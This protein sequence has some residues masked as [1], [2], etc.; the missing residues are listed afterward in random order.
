MGEWN[1]VNRALQRVAAGEPGPFAKHAG[2]LW[3]KSDLLMI[4]NRQL[5]T[6][7]VPRNT[8][9]SGLTGASFGYTLQDKFV[10]D[11]VLA[12]ATPV[13]ATRLAAWLQANPNELGLGSVKIGRTGG[14]VS[15]HAELDPDQ[16]PASFREQMNAYL[17]P[18]MEMI[19][20]KNRAAKA[21]IQ[22]RDDPK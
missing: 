16:L 18:M 17:G 7:L 5:T 19:G 3:A 2:E 1:A 21:V 11:A 10:V 14:Q 12:T 22:G 13:A 8:A 15:V 20:P 9:T 6:A 4:A